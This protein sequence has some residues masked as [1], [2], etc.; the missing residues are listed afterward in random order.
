M[1]NVRHPFRRPGLFRRDRRPGLQ[2][3]LPRHPELDPAR[4]PGRTGHRGGQGGL[5]PGAVSSSGSRQPG[6]ARRRRRG[7]F[8]QACSSCSATSTAITTI[9]RPSNNC[10]RPWAARIARLH[11]LAI[12]P[13]L[14]GVVAEHLAQSGCA[15]DARVV[16]EKPFG[17]DLE[18]A[19]ELNRILARDVRRIAHL[20]DRPLPG[21][22]A[23]PQHP[24]LPVR[25]PVPRADLE[26]QLHRERPDHD[27]RELRRPGARR[28]LRRGRRDPRRG[29]EPHAPGRRDAGDGAARQQFARR[30]PRREGQGVAGDPAAGSRP[31]SSAASIA[32]TARK[33]ESPPTPRSR[34]SPRSSWRSTRGAGPTCRS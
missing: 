22:G 27:G 15:D 13:S 26:P 9:R 30:H 2:E 3:G 1:S 14:F 16:I 8:Q 7:R 29:P 20:P 6:Q 19:R 17:R 18:S 11:Y 34:R 28:I 24:V 5:G 33:K 4:A 23:G 21:Q 25:Q 12:P 10:A 31:T 32:A